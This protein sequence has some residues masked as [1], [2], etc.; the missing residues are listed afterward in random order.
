[1]K[2]KECKYFIDPLANRMQITNVTSKRI[3]TALVYAFLKRRDRFDESSEA[4]IR[5]KLMCNLIDEYTFDVFVSAAESGNLEN[6]L[7]DHEKGFNPDHINSEYIAPFV[8]EYILC[9][10]N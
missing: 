7:S 8:W 2:N 1:M 5:K 3:L 4:G 6:I 9:N 10:G